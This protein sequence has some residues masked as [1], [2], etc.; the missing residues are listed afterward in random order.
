MDLNSITQMYRPT[1]IDFLPEWREGYARLAGGAWLFSEPQPS[2]RALVDLESLSWP[3]LKLQPDGLEIAAT[4]TIAEL[5][6]FRAPVEWKASP[7]F[8]ECSQSLQASFKIWNAA[9]VGGNI[10][11]SLPAGAM[12][13]LTSALEGVGT[14]WSRNGASREVPIV[15]FVTGNH[16][17]VLAP[18][19]LLRQVWL[20]GSAL[21]KRF[22]FRRF[23]LTSLGRSSV[24]LIGTLCP[25]RRALRLTVTAA[26]VRPIQLVFEPFPS[27]AGLISALDELVRRDLFFDDPHGSSE[28]CRHLTYHYAEQIRIELGTVDH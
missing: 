19:E 28:H 18:G 9:T 3:A 15:D 1:S 13:A 10:C 23:S 22:A 17:N 6:A 26:T 24:L 21:R 11:L 27:A 7:L 20:P 12:I 14:I 16:T 4:C 25:I 2:T 5:N 8:R